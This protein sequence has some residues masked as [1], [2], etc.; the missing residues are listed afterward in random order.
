MS[1]SC[2]QTFFQRIAG[3]KEHGERTRR[4]VGGLNLTAIRCGPASAHRTGLHTLLAASCH[5][6]LFGGG[7]QPHQQA[8]WLQLALG[9]LRPACQSHVS[10]GF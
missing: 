2:Q 4:F 6:L 8:A 5:G 7:V 3:L 1:K 9:C 10:L